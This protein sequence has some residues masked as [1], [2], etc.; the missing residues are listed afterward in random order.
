MPNT[1]ANVIN[2]LMYKYISVM[3]NFKHIDTLKYVN[4]I[5]TFKIIKG[6]SLC[7]KLNRKNNPRSIKIIV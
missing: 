2:E 6:E 7:E 3:Q 5:V 4:V 1:M